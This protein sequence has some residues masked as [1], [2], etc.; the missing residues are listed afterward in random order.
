M[1]NSQL[2]ISFQDCSSEEIWVLVIIVAYMREWEDAAD[3]LLNGYGKIVF[4]VGTGGRH[5]SFTV[6]VQWLVCCVLPFPH[7]GHNSD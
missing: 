7:V 4:S 1:H 5:D 6:H 2:L 3:Q